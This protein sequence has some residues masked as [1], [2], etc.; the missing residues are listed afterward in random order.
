MP[1][2]STTN[3]RSGSRPVTPRN[4]RETKL[5]ALYEDRMDDLV[6]LRN[7]LLELQRHALTRDDNMALQVISNALSDC[8]SKIVD[9]E[10][11][12]TGLVN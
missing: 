12:L 10:T 6:K 5:M 3:N 8:Q 2:N 9:V 1:R 7:S 4:I 11:S